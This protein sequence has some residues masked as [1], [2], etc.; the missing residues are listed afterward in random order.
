VDPGNI[1]RKEEPRAEKADVLCMRRQWEPDAPNLLSEDQRERIF[2]ADETLQGLLQERSDLKEELDKIQEDPEQDYNRVTIQA[3]LKCKGRALNRRRINLKKHGLDN[4]RDSFFENRSSE[5]LRSQ[6]PME[7]SAT[8]PKGAPIACRTHLVDVLYGTEAPALVAVEAVIAHCTNKEST[9]SRPVR[10]AMPARPQAE[11]QAKFTPDDDQLLVGLKD[12]ESLTWKEVTSYFPGRTEGS[13]KQRY[14]RVKAMAFSDSRSSEDAGNGDA[15]PPSR[16]RRTPPPQ[17]KS[18]PSTPK[19][20]KA[21]HDSRGFLRPGTVRGRTLRELSAKC[22][23]FVIE[24]LHSPEIRGRG[25][26]CEFGDDICFILMKISLIPLW[27]LP[28]C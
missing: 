7:A 3:A 9:P 10:P 14:A 13:L 18:G 8:P 2:D 26:S 11:S 5:I 15:I 19:R 21:N 23:A 28:T 25:V 1:F 16:K 24:E 22:P 12:S 27:Q 17:Q 6:Q 20:R 4:E